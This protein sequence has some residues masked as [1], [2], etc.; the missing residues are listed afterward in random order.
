MSVSSVPPS[1]GSSGGSSV[2]PSSTS[3]ATPASIIAQLG[4][5]TTLPISA[6][7]AGLLNIDSIPLVNLQNQV[8][9]IQTEI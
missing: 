6:I 9:G 8:T 3:T 5:G 7:L 4:I 2:A 1:S